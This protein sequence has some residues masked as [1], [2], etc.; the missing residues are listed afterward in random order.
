[1]KDSFRSRMFILD[2]NGES[3]YKP[4]RTKMAAT[5]PVSEKLGIIKVVGPVALLASRVTR[6]I[7]RAYW[8]AVIFATLVAG[9]R[10]R[11]G[12]YKTRLR[13]MG[14]KLT[15]K[16]ESPS[17]DGHKIRDFNGSMIIIAVEIDAKAE[18]KKENGYSD[19]FTYIILAWWYIEW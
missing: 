19:Q 14:S 5:C 9:E 18:F 13:A 2:S 3:T 8:E 7:I 10:Q 17:G 12:R 1:M 6:W 11:Y 15:C 4:K 16:R